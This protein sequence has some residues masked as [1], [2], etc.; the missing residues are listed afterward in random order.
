LWSETPSDS[1]ISNS[2][3]RS[4][5]H[6]GTRVIL[7]TISPESLPIYNLIL[8]LYTHCHGDWMSFQ[9]QSAISETELRYFLEYATQFLANC[10]NYRGFG[11]SKFVPRLTPERFEALVEGVPEAKGIFE[12]IG[13]RQ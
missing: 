11:D 12:S 7:R 9:R 13:G 1:K 10:G 4:A 8:A 5:A 2:A 3:L 6:L